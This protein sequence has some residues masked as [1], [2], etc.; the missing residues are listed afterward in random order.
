LLA[1][2]AQHLRERA[3]DAWAGVEEVTVRA[4]VT[5]AGTALVVRPGPGPLPPLPAGDDPVAVVGA[6]NAVALR[7]DPTVHERVAGTD[8]AISPGSFFQPGPAGAETLLELVRRSA[9]L[10]VGRRALDLYAGI[11]LFA[12]GLSQDGFDVTAVESSRAAARDAEDNLAFTGARVVRAPVDRFL[13]DHDAPIDVVVLDPPRRG[14]GADV[15]R[16]LAGLAPERLVYVSCDPASL[17]RDARDLVKAGYRLVEAVPVDQFGH[18]ASI[19]VVAT[20][21]EAS[22]S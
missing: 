12:W 20:F 18:T 17:A 9:R 19:E 11:G 15:V 8:F 3:G 6:T 7:G 1:E 4:G 10:A 16:R 21:L 22:S 2:A 5:G 13:R 14:V